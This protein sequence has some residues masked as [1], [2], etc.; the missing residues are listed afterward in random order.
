V[1]V[2]SNVLAHSPLP[3]PEEPEE[4]DL[5]E[6]PLITRQNLKLCT[7]RNDDQNILS[8]TDDELIVKL[9]KH[10]T[11]ALIGVFQF[12]VLRGAIHIN[13][14]NIGALSF[15]GEK[16]QVYTAYVPATHPISKI[17]GLD[18]A[19]HVQFISCEE[20]RPLANISPLFADI[21]NV[22]RGSHSFKVVSTSPAAFHGF[23]I[24]YIVLSRFRV[25]RVIPAVM[26]MRLVTRPL[27]HFAR[28]QSPKPM[29]SLGR[30]ALKQALKTGF[31]P[32]KIV[33]WNRLS[34]SLLVQ[35]L[36]GNLLSFGAC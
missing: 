33:P 15:N 32:S 18:N 20:P 13:G 17:R 4:S 1:P 35:R 27:I 14:A 10:T 28:S 11:I 3:E 5:D 19:N 22:A 25:F 7:W 26:Y 23:M 31:E 36:P 8:N 16:D 24:A 29:R 30:C 9:S 6:E 12:K 34:P 2:P 21:W